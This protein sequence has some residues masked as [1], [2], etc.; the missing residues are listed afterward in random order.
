MSVFAF[1]DDFENSLKTDPNDLGQDVL[2][3]LLLF[4][5]SVVGVGVV[6]VF[7]TRRRL[8]LKQ[9]RLPAP[10]LEAGGADGREDGEGRRVPGNADLRQRWVKFRQ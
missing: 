9:R 3:V 2:L 6:A 10:V 7:P 8:Q 1:P 5:V 4:G